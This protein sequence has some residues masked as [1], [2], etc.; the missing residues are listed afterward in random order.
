MYWDVH[1]HL[2]KLAGE[3]APLRNDFLIQVQNLGIIGFGLAGVSPEDWD[4][5]L[6]LKQ[7]FPDLRFKT[8]FG[9]HPEWVSQRSQQELEEDLD[10]LARKL[11]YCD[12]LGEVGLDR[13]EPWNE[14]WDQ[15]VMAFQAQIELGRMAQKPLVIH[16]VRAHQDVQRILN[17][18]RED[19]R[20]GFVHGFTG[21]MEEARGYLELNLSLSFGRHL[22]HP[23]AERLRTIAK[24]VP[25]DR[26]MIESDSLESSLEPQSL[27]KVAQI[28][29]EVRN[30]SF[31]SIL[32]QS[33]RNFLGLCGDQ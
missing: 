11:P 31:E 23:N 6:D 7:V 3:A 18:Y 12:F 13:R 16:G 20:G 1:C 30:R 4:R 9:L 29:G 32:E 8:A 14:S 15:Q 22:G 27:V 25:E 24:W 2:T 10:H 28:M 19:L 17:L 26:F 21:S 33:S 5:Q